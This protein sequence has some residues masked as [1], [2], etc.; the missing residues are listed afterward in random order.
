MDNSNNKENN[1]YKSNR[2]NSDG[3]DGPV[4]G[5]VLIP[6]TLNLDDSNSSQYSQG[7]DKLIME[8]QIRKIE[9]KNKQ[10][11]PTAVTESHMQQSLINLA[12]QATLT[13]LSRRILRSWDDVEGRNGISIH[14]PAIMV[15]ECS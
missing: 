12:D 4:F 14:G 8:N 7:K 10:E 5:S 2:S 13:G 1:K 3:S 6:S 9:T 15:Q 11:K